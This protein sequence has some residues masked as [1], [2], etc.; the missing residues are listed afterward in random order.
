MAR[1]IDKDESRD[2][3]TLD[4]SAAVWGG[5]AGALMFVITKVLLLGEGVGGIWA[6]FR[7]IATFALR[8]RV[9]EPDWE[10]SPLMLII[11]IVLH[12]LLSL[13]F[14]FII[15]FVLHRWGLLVGILGGAALG[16][17]IYLINYYTFSLLFPWFFATDGGWP[18]AA[19]HIA[20]GAVAGGVYELLEE[21]HAR[22]RERI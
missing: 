3:I 4:V 13:L 5:L 10:F 2:N 14:A 21:N 9:I 12:L 20:F 7:P 11:G 18:T 16:L 15:T 19:A 17:A 6:T 22:S 8:E 1:V